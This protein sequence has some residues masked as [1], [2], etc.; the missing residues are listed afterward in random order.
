MFSMLL[1]LVGGRRAV[2]AFAVCLRAREGAPPWQRFPSRGPTRGADSAGRPPP[3]ARA[4]NVIYAPKITS[5]FL[6][7]SAQDDRTFLLEE[8]CEI[9]AIW[10]TFR[11]LRSGH[12]CTKK[13]CLRL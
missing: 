2:G 9:C 8:I 6:E 12:P 13:S 5:L 1:R 11:R 7:T 3:A 4:R 10:C